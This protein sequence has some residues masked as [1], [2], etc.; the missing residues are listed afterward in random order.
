MF[1]IVPIRSMNVARKAARFGQGWEIPPEVGK[2]TLFA[3][4]YS[5]AISRKKIVAVL[6]PKGGKCYAES[7]AVRQEVLSRSRFAV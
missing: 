2:K 1:L 7:E 4:G 5:V 6:D 3:K